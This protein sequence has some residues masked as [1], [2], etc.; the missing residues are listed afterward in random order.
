M[1]ARWKGFVALVAAQAIFLVA[2]AGYH[3]IVRGQ[4]PAILLK[5]R[6]VDPRD[7]LRG[8]YMILSYDISDV[9]LGGA[10][11]LGNRLGAGRDVG[12]C[13]ALNLSILFEDHFPG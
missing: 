12:L 3:E 8:D 2:W 10:V 7:L 13:Q 4:V 9:P 11:G 5:G 6:P 1:N